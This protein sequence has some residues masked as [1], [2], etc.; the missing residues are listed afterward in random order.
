MDEDFLK[1]GDQICLYSD[2]VNG[3]LTSISFNNPVINI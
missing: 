3:Y 2:S 1:I